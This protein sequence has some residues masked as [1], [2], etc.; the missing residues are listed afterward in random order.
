MAGFNVGNP[1]LGNMPMP[2]NGPNG[3]M[4]MPEERIEEANYEGKLNTC[5]YEYFCHKGQYE[6]ARALKNSGMLF[7]PPLVEG[8]ANGLDDNMH[9]DSKASIDKNRPDDLPDVKGMS[10]GQGGP[11]LLSW[12]ACFWDIWSARRKDTRASSSAMQYV[13]HTQV[14]FSRHVRLFQLTQRTEPS[15]DAPATGPTNVPGRPD[16]E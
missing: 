16:N 15:K 9:A 10:D 8:D 2:N 13:Q 12:F 3:A 5:I 7:E 6:S 11:F 1:A 14:C 4:R